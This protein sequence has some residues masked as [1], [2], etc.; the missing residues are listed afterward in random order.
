MMEGVIDIAVVPKI[1]DTCSWQKFD[2][3][4]YIICIDDGDKNSKLYIS[5]EVIELLDLV[6]GNNSLEDIKAI[7]NEKAKYKLTD[8]T[9]TQIFNKKLSGYG[10]FD[11]DDDRK[12]QVKNK[13]IWL[14]MTL[15]NGSIVK[16]ISRLMTPVFNERFFYPVLFTSF[17]ATI[18][19]FFFVDFSHIYNTVDTN[20]FVNFIIINLLTLVVHEFGHSAACEKFGANSGSIGFG[21]YIMSPVF[22]S[23]V[24]DAWRLRRK[25]RLIV[26]LGGIYVQLII[27]AF[28]SIYFFATGNVT[29]IALI[30]LIFLGVIFNLNPFLRFDGYWALCDYTN[31]TNLRE[32]ATKASV[33]F[34]GWVIGRNKNFHP[35]KKEIFLIAY[36]NFSMLVIINFLLIMVINQ[37][38]SILYFP[39][40]LYV[41][42]SEIITKTPSDFSWYKKHI[43]ALLPLMAFYIMFG[44]SIYQGLKKYL[45]KRYGI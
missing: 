34:Y 29:V 24:S 40:N 32:R 28:L 26:D 8:E 20:L 37:H 43:I 35:T 15:F 30:S 22:F 11:V 19:P 10:I 5:K 7:Y 33:K 44:I 12:I 41:F 25:E 1:K 38:D 18:I 36:G 9:I 23:D 31:M 21:L 14:K 17:I 13:Y 16:K 39:K 4:N 2:E 27:T 3:R 45:K 42:I 6:D